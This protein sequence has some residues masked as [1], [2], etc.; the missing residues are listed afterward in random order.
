MREMTWILTI[1]AYDWGFGSISAKAVT[2]ILLPSGA[3][4]L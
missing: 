2:G 3:G 1:S 4:M